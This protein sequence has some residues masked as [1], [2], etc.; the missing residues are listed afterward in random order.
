MGNLIKKFGLKNYP[1]SGVF[2]WVGRAD[3]S[4]LD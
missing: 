3:W 1:Q 2:H 4:G